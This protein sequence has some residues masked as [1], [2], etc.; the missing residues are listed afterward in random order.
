[1]TRYGVPYKGSKATIALW[2]V[3]NLPR[4]ET[5]VDLFAGGCAVTHAAMV[6]G[7]FERFIIN[8]LMDTPK[9]FE[10][11]IR[12]ELDGMNTV[13]TREEFKACD[14]DA[15]RLMYSFGNNRGSYLWSK[16]LEPVKVEAS[17]MLASHSMHERRMHYRAFMRNLRAYIENNEA[18]P[19]DA[20]H[21]GSL[22]RLESLERLESLQSLQS[23]QSL[24]S[25]ERLERDYRLVGIPSNSTVYADP[26]YRG[27]DCKAYGDD[28]TNFD[29][30][31][32]DTW[33]ANVPCMVVVSEYTAPDGCVE[34]ASRVKTVTSAATVTKKAVERLFVHEKW[35]DVY[36]ERMAVGE[37]ASLF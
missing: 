31:A 15:L 26:P 5:L 36:R 27:T 23:L 14:D 18:M 28:G 34:V 6:S 7:K 17:K 3:E 21:D 19:D 16:E 33:L 1:M 2:I 11:A 22:Q 4:A 25:L 29:F 9:V 24:E 12:G 20:R 37:T 8:D 10:A 30:A 35:L 32:F 13:L